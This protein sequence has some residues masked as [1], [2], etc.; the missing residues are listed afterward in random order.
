MAKKKKVMKKTVNQE[1]DWKFITLLT[2]I[3]LVGLTLLSLI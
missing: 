3:T 1:I 2:A